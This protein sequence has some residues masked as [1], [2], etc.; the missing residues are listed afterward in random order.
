MNAWRKSI[1]DVF[2]KQSWTAPLHS[3]LEFAE[4]WRNRVEKKM[5]FVIVMETGLK[6]GSFIFI[7]CG[8]DSTLTAALCV[9]I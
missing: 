7:S 6:D 3:R 9:N 8:P 2:H 1:F 5:S 4:P